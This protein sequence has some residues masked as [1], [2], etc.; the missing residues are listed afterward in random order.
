MGL[1]VWQLLNY[2]RRP[3]FFLHS[4]YTHGV[5]AEHL[6]S[7]TLPQSQS[8]L[9][10]PMSLTETVPTPPSLPRSSATFTSGPSVERTPSKSSPTHSPKSRNPRSQKSV[11]SFSTNQTD[12]GWGAH[13]WVTLVDP[14]ASLRVYPIVLLFEPATSQTQTSFFA[15]P[16]TGQVSWDPPVGNFVLPPSADGEWWELSDDSRGGLPYYYQTKTG[17]TVWERPTSAFVIPLGIIQV[18]YTVHLISYFPIWFQNTALGRRLSQ[19]TFNRFSKSPPDDAPG[20]ANTQASVYRRSRSYTGPLQTLENS[21]SNADPGHRTEVRR[22]SSTSANPRLPPL[23][24]N[25]PPIP[26]SPDNTDVPPSPSSRRTTL[27]NP[28]DHK[29]IPNGKPLLNGDASYPD[30][31]PRARSKSSSYVSHRPPQPQSLNAAVELLTSSQ[32]ESGHGSLSTAPSSPKTPKLIIPST[33]T[34]DKSKPPPSPRRPIPATPTSRSASAPTVAG[35]VISG[36]KLNHG[37]SCFTLSTY[38]VR[39]D[40]SSCDNGHESSQEPSGRETHLGGTSYSFTNA[41]DPNDAWFWVRFTRSIAEQSNP[42]LSL[43]HIQFSP[44]ISFPIFSNS[45]NRILPS[46]TSQPT[47]LDSY[48]EDACLLHR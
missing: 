20:P 12:E 19:T 22:S 48:S 14:Q 15:C 28:K 21:G 11:S 43:E 17:E 6:I 5:L 24:S 45:L 8:L 7:F 30:A 10:A 31:S 38:Y 9:I 37:K 26:G 42:I 23:T 13:F 47:A 16:A 2:R 25:L 44:T 29:G 46:S 33:P 34:R 4:L 36:P 18:R 39:T 1:P 41:I 35:K 27:S 32:S 40:V 3:H